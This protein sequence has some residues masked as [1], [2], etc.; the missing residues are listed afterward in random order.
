MTSS[1]RQSITHNN[2]LSSQ[3][4]S[5][6][7]AIILS[8]HIASTYSATIYIYNLKM[9]ITYLLFLFFAFVYPSA[10]LYLNTQIIGL[11]IVIIVNII[12]YQ[13]GICNLILNIK[14][15]N[16]ILFFLLHDFP[17]FG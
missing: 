6:T 14:T 8:I 12:Q 3:S 13:V 16:H 9:L 17:I 7:R 1:E 11:N 4:T 5:N 2:V 10:K 15:N